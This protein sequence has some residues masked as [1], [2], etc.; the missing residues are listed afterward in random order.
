MGSHM[1]NQQQRAGG[2]KIIG[3][4]MLQHLGT[5]VAKGLSQFTIGDDLLIESTIIETLFPDR[6]HNKTEF[7]ILAHVISPNFLSE[8]STLIRRQPHEAFD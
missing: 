1:R 6:G 2:R 8:P 3:E 7:Q 4:V 5:V